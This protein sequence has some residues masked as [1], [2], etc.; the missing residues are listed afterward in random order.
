MARPAASNWPS[1]DVALTVSLDGTSYVQLAELVPPEKGNR[2]R[3]SPPRAREGAECT[4]PLRQDLGSLGLPTRALGLGEIEVF[5]S[6]AAMRT[7]K[8]RYYVNA[9]EGFRFRLVC[10]H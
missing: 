7:G 4:H 3:T 5:G 9:D 8:D 2:T 1:R 6:G 10:Q